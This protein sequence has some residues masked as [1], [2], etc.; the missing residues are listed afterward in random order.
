MITFA[1]LRAN[2]A[3]FPETISGN[4]VMSVWMNLPATL[5]EGF[6]VDPAFGGG[7]GESVSVSAAPLVG[8]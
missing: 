2:L 7:D 5:R 6:V 1:R 3:G 4:F 8:P